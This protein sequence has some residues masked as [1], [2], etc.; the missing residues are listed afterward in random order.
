VRGNAE[1]SLLGID[2][3]EKAKTSAKLMFLKGFE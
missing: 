3:Q 2:E 1:S